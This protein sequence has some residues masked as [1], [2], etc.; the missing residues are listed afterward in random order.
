MGTKT[1]DM[2]YGSTLWLLI[3]TCFGCGPSNPPSVPLRTVKTQGFQCQCP[4]EWELIPR[5]GIDVILKCKVG[6]AGTTEEIFVHLTSNA[7][8]DLDTRIDNAEF[9]SA[10]QISKI[11]VDGIQSTRITYEKID[12]IKKKRLMN[13]QLLIPGN[14]AISINHSDRDSVMNILP[15]VD[16][17]AKSLKFQ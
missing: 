11:D 17:L 13:Y 7:I 4:A 14:M 8:N 16:A 12:Y 3:A 15:Y 6:F 5:G 2:R 10:I 9:E 1:K